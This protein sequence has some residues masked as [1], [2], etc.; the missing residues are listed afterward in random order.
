ML[1]RVSQQFAEGLP[2]DAGVEVA[3]AGPLLCP[4]SHKIVR[5]YARQVARCSGRSFQC[6]RGEP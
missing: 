2:L 4:L 1:E 6:V 3:N 5:P